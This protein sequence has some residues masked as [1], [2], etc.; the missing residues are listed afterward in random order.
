MLILTNVSILCC[1]LQNFF[2]FFDFNIYKRSI[3]RIFPLEKHFKMVSHF[4][5]WAFFSQI[6]SKIGF[7]KIKHG[8]VPK[9]RFLE[10][11]KNWDFLNFKGPSKI[12]PNFWKIWCQKKK[13]FCFSFFGTGTKRSNSLNLGLMIRYCVQFFI[14]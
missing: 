12:V 10:K 11:E 3:K 6:F 1:C 13:N 9:T 5:V 14:Y 7:F 4:F 8:P 2:L